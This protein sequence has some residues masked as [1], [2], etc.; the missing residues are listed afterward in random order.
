MTPKSLWALDIISEA[1]FEYD[2]S[3]YPIRHDNYGLQ[4]GPHCPYKI[5]L[6]SG[7]H[8]VEF[9]ITTAPLAS[10]NI[11]V[12]GGGYFRLLPYSVTKR[13]LD[14]R[15]RLLD[16]PF[17]FYLHPWELDPDQPRVEGASAKSRFRHYLNLSGM[18]TRLRRLLGDLSWGRMDEVFLDKGDT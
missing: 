18:E 2:S 8:L 16:S 3:I 13:L 1:G 6:A 4:G 12:G 9:P 10:L 14:R 15:Q 17:V 5:E 7:S 11:P